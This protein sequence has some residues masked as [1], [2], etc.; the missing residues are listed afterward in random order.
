VTSEFDKAS[1]TENAV[2]LSSRNRQI[3]D[4]KFLLYSLVP[5]YMKDYFKII[6]S[7]TAQEKLGLY[8][9]KKVRISLPP[10][11]IQKKISGIYGLSTYGGVF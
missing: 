4:S 2:K 1:L 9:I 8:K 5:K 11:R 6:A 3:L 7:G 10:I